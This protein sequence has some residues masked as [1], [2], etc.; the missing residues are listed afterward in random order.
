[1]IGRAFAFI[2][3]L[4][5][6]IMIVVKSESLVGSIAPTK[7]A[8]AQPSITQTLFVHNLT[9]YREILTQI[10]SNYLFHYNQT[11]KSNQNLPILLLPKVKI[12]L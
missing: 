4:I 8:V 11:Q 10:E 9:A 3:F 2:T 1:M 6:I 5:F 12:S 7:T